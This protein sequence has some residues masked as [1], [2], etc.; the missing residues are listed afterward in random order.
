MDDDEYDDY[1]LDQDR[2]DLRDRGYFNE[3][4]DQG[5]VEGEC[6]YAHAAVGAVEYLHHRK[7]HGQNRVI[8]SPQD[9]YNNLVYGQNGVEEDAQEDDEVDKHAKTSMQTL[10]WICENGCVLQAAC[11]YTGVAVPP[12]PLAERRN[13]VRLRIETFKPV[14]LRNLEDHVRTIGPVIAAIDWVKELDN[15][16]AEDVIYTGPVDAAA[17]DGAEGHSVL[18]MGFGPDYWLVRN[19]HGVNWGNAGYAKFT[20]AKVHGRF[21]I[22]GCWAPVGIAYR[23]PGGADYNA[24]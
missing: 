12:K 18:V 11:P 2:V 21:L 5:R 10:A 15:W 20:R 17:F 24:I 14:K 8:L 4:T 22:D 13:D 7:Q 23:D 3:V 9:I 19:S 6:C 1:Y 16:G